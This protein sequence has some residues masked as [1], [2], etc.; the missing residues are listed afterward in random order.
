MIEK[1]FIQLGTFLISIMK[2]VPEISVKICVQW[3]NG[4][5]CQYERSSERPL[6]FFSLRNNSFTSIFHL[7]YCILPFERHQL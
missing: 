4:K 6:C 1:L 5:I 7:N 3:F 2:V